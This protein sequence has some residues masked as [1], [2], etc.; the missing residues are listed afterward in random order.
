MQRKHSDECKWEVPIDKLVN[1]LGCLHSFPNELALDGGIYS[2]LEGSTEVLI[3]PEVASKTSKFEID[4]SSYSIVLDGSTDNSFSTTGQAV[5][6][7]FFAKFNT[8][9]I[10]PFTYWIP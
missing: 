3:F 6:V 7:E 8:G 9:K 2:E 10:T 1:G 4:F 5:D